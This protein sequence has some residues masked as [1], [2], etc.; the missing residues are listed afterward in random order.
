[1][2]HKAARICLQLGLFS[3]FLVSVYGVFEHFGHSFSCLSFT[4][5]F[6]VSCWIQDVQNRVFATLGQ[7]NWLAAYLVALIPISIAL[8]ITAK[9]PVYNPAAAGPYSIFY[10]LCLLFTKSRSAFLGLAAALFVS[11]TIILLKR[12]PKYTKTISLGVVL[13][14][15]IGSIFVVKQFSR[16]PPIT[17]TSDQPITSTDLISESGD[18]RQIVWTGAIEIWKHHPILG[19]GPETFAY[20]YYWY[21]PREHNDVSEWD[22]LYNKAHNEYLNYLATTGTIGFVGYLIMIT[23]FIF[24][25]TKKVLK[26]K[27]NP[28]SQFY[29]LN[30]F[31]AAFVSILVTNFFG[32]SVVVVSLLFFLIPAFDFVFSQPDDQNLPAPAF[33]LNLPRHLLIL[34]IFAGS[35][36]LLFG[37]VNYWRADLRYAQGD[38]LEKAGTYDQA[39][40][41]LQEAINLRGNEPVYHNSLALPASGYA[42]LA[43]KQNQTDLASRSAAYAI[44]ESDLALQT[45][46]FN[47]NFLKDRTKVYF[48]LTD[49]NP[50]NL[51]KAIDTLS[52]ATKIAPTDPKIKYN[53]GVF[54]ASADQ[55]DLAIK[56]LEETIALKPNFEDAHFALA[57]FYQKR[58]QTPEA[59]KE[60][61]YIL[62]RIN[63]GS[64]RALQKLKELNY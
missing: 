32:F 4:G 5:S 2:S 50:Q 14:L 1:M 39:V 10:L 22:F 26:S 40:N 47:I 41:I 15:V 57:L 3:A 17:Q 27:N 54:L 58:G 30:S 21:R 7:P 53:L 59:K 28:D 18:I 48:R 64:Q 37:I 43:F 25:A 60:L 42:V 12:F 33:P 16:P 8:F 34:A 36:Y 61:E 52:Q 46:P 23:S 29:I 9:K 31:L 13:I 20:S 55:L 44:Q 63:P 38:K 51:N 49:I 24:W 6:N 56:Y 19:T 45:S 11:A 62:Q 35:V